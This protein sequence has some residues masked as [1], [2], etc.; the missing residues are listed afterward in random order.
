MP[1][2]DEEA[3]D[4]DALLTQALTA[5]NLPDTLTALRRLFV[6]KLDFTTATGT[7]PLDPAGQRAEATRLASREG[8]NVIAV[9]F[10]QSDRLRAADVRAALKSAGETLSGDLLLV[11]ANDTRSRIDFV[12]P[13][14]LGGRELLRRMV[15]RRDQPHR[16][17]SQQIAGIY[18]ET[19]RRTDIRAALGHAY[20][21]EAVT[22][23]FF[24][25]CHDI[26]DRVMDLI[27]GL[28]DDDDRRLF[29]QTLFNRLMFLYFLQRKG[30][31][32]FNGD[33]EYLEA[34]WNSRRPGENFYEIRL[35]LLFFMALNNP[36]NA[37]LDVARSVMEPEIGRVPF[38]NGGL[39]EQT[40]LDNSPG[41]VVPDEAIDLILNK[42]FRRFNFTIEE[43]T[44]YDVEVAVDPEMLGKVFEELVTGRHETGSYY[45]PRPIVSFMCREGLKGYLTTALTTSRGDAT[46]ERGGARRCGIRRR[47]RP[48]R[49]QR[50]R[51][52]R[53]PRRPR[54]G[55]GARSGLWQRRLP[56]RHA[57]RVGRAS[58][59]TLQR[60]IN[61]QR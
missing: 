58:A 5:A 17:I 55:H 33:R 23:D 26:F 28:P 19:E 49:S 10:P 18:A 9:H 53:D 2:V 24:R 27:T 14:S 16:T 30:W 52:S 3:R 42:L 56:A 61:L 37:D 43:S 22:R 47:S 13:D 4:V 20:D 21:V 25:T 35:R 50:C 15:V 57:S 7:I 48:V 39:F 1:V 32:T 46:S 36:S 31:L 59:I 44:P 41:V 40:P 34:L 38:L 11:A 54:T 8:V 29:C 60:E 12:Y 45:T 51:R 6:E